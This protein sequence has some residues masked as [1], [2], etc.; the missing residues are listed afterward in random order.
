MN[1]PREPA[2]AGSF[3]PADRSMLIETIRDCFLG[4]LGPG[5]LPVS[6]ESREERR[7][8]G[9]ISPHAGYIY[10]GP[11]AAHGYYQLSKEK[12]PQAIIIIGPNHTG[13]GQRVS[14][15]QGGGWETPLGDVRINQSLA[16]KII[17]E[18]NVLSADE[19]AHVF[20]HSIEVQ[21]PFL[22]FIYGDGFEIVPICMGD[23]TFET[24]HELGNAISR[25]LEDS[26]D[27]ACLIIASTD[28]THYEPAETAGEK[29]E[30]VLERIAELDADGLLQTVADWGISMCGAGPV[31]AMIIAAQALGART[32]KL[33]AYRNSGDV[34]GDYS[35]VVGYASVAVSM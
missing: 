23:Q 5:K 8:L 26:E 22:Q 34:T 15:Y 13:L 2:A 25:S 4:R 33:L 32:A 28:F 30:K 19:E 29:D 35:S 21:L 20:E 6:K 24:S 14:V 31:A 1:K 9:L 7:I 16:Q 18:S 17:A 12:E 3:Y 11:V 10:S 27:A